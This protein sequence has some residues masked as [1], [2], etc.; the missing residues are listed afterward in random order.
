[1]HLGF[2]LY[3]GSFVEE[4]VCTIREYLLSKEKGKKGWN[5]RVDSR[6]CWK[7]SPASLLIPFSHSP[8]GWL[9]VLIKWQ[10]WSRGGRYRRQQNE[11]FGVIITRPQ[12]MEFSHIVVPQNSRVLRR[13]TFPQTSQIRNPGYDVSTSTTQESCFLTFCFMPQ[14]EPRGK[15][16]SVSYWEDGLSDR[17]EEKGDEWMIQY[18]DKEHKLWNQVPGVWFLN[19]SLASWMALDKPLNSLSSVSS[20]NWR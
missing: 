1:M 15:S 11:E 17:R 4:N 7:E 19:M 14:L 3:F 2:P 6:Q 10:P 5:K 9:W 12:S 16:S 8:W 18:G 13:Y 20:M